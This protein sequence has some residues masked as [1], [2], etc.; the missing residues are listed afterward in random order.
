[1][2]LAK[3]ESDPAAARAE[4]TE[5]CDEVA[6]ALEELRELARGL[7]PAV[8]TRH[9]L[10]AAVAAL[11]GRATVP[12]EVVEVPN[13]RLPES[14]EAAAYY[15]IS[16]AL[17]NVTKYAQASEVRLRVAASDGT[18]VVE[19]SD[20]GVGGA[21]PATGSGIQGLADR[22]EALGGTLEVASP[23]GKGTSLRA[24]IPST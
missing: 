8:L 1:M 5:A 14:V 17:T 18:V 7:H 11:A 23:P 9:G 20:D 3:L 6:M 22:I 15:V 2:A 19:V 21:D 4:L 24:E 13:E 10:R 12:V 16:E